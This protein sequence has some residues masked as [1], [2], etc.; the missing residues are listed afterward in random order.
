MKKLLMIVVFCVVLLSLAGCRNTAR[1]EQ[2]DPDTDITYG[3]DRLDEPR[4]VSSVFATDTTPNPLAVDRSRPIIFAT[5]TASLIIKPNNELWAWGSGN[6]GG[7]S[8]VNLQAPTA[9][10]ENVAV[11]SYAPGSHTMVVHTDGR[12]TGWG[13]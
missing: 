8:L 6:F 1:N 3:M 7:G 5:N 9:V 4:A 10:M 12:L 13:Q 2:M 11:F